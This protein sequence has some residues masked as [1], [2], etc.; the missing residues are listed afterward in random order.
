MASS[1]V[2]LKAFTYPQMDYFSPFMDME[3]TYW[4]GDIFYK[5]DGLEKFFGVV[6]HGALLIH[7]FRVKK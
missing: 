1:R 2:G 5:Y 6:G 4:G 7:I 3:T